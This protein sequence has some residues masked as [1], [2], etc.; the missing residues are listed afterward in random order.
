MKARID[1]DV[2][3]DFEWEPLAGESCDDSLRG[4]QVALARTVDEMLGSSSSSAVRKL[5]VVD[6]SAS[7]VVYDGEDDGDITPVD[8]LQEAFMRRWPC[9]RMVAW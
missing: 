3:G 7:E 5:R 1:I 4:L 2:S 9:L 6:V 8:L